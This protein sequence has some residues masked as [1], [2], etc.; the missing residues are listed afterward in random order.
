[1]WR[2]V[3]VGGGNDSRL[4]GGVGGT[5]AVLH[6]NNSTIFHGCAYIQPQSTTSALLVLATSY[7][8]GAYVANIRECSVLQPPSS[9][10]ALSVR[11]SRNPNDLH[12][13]GPNHIIVVAFKID[14]IMP[15][16]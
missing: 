2:G 15:H 13:P 6:S 10:S 3:G 12:Q 8:V 1:M 5:I 14:H 16:T 9:Y 11:R 4:G 7:V